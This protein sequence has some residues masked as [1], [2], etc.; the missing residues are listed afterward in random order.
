[1]KR[2]APSAGDDDDVGGGGADGEGGPGDDVIAG[3]GTR[4]GAGALQHALETPTAPIAR[5][6]VASEDALRG[7][8]PQYKR[9]VEIARFSFDRDRRLHMD[10]RS[11]VRRA[12]KAVHGAVGPRVGRR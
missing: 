9:P 6:A 5:L 12:H 1:M 2:R 4:E 7:E 3:V 10:A 11:L 8:M